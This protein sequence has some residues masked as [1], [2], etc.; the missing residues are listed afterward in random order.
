MTGKYGKAIDPHIKWFEEQIEKSKDGII[1]IRLKDFRDKVLGQHYDRICDNTVC[2]GVKATF[3]RRGIHIAI[4]NHR[5]SGD[6]IL[7]MTT[8]EQDPQHRICKYY[9]NDITHE[10]LVRDNAKHVHKLE[11]EENFRKKKRQ[12][13]IDAVKIYK[14]KVAE[15][16]TWIGEEMNK[17]E[18]RIFVAS[19]TGVQ[20]ILGYNFRMYAGNTIF[21][22]IKIAMEDHG[23]VVNKR[24]NNDIHKDFYVEFRY[25]REDEKFVWEEQG[26]SSRREYDEY[27]EWDRNCRKIKKKVNENQDNPD[28]IFSDKEF[29]KRIFSCQDV[30]QYENITDSH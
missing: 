17:D 2:Q 29:V 15:M 14:E 23:I 3:L 27:L 8:C 11:A 20:N 9:G 1:N 25:K 26:F 4:G 18:N 16:L 13:S 28:S 12:F 21:K 24:N 22:N 7:I 6:K 30:E 19:I 10:E 5:N